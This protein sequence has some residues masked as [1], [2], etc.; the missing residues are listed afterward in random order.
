M[1]Q[2]FDP[3]SPAI[4]ASTNCPLCGHANHCV[5]AADGDTS[6]CWCMSLEVPEGLLASLPDGAEVSCVCEACIR[7]YSDAQALI[8]DQ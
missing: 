1:A 4:V 6:Q 5:V 8:T 2:L 3:T 7:A